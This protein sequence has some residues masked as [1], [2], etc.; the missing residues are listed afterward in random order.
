MKLNDLAEAVAAIVFAAS[1]LALTWFL[2]LLA[3][4]LASKIVN[5]EPSLPI[6]QEWI[7]EDVVCY[8]QGERVIN[9]ET[10]RGYE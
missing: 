2:L 1:M 7:K 9:C 10:V 5:K 4:G 8:M 6:T 3:T